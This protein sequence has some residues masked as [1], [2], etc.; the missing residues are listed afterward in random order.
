[1]ASLSTFKLI[2]KCLSAVI[3]TADFTAWQ[4]PHLFY[5]L[6]EAPPSH[7]QKMLPRIARIKRKLLPAI[8]EK[9]VKFVAQKAGG[10]PALLANHKIS[11]SPSFEA[12]SGDPAAPELS[13]SRKEQLAKKPE[14]ERLLHA[15]HREKYYFLS[16][17]SVAV[18]L[19]ER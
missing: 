11:A 18:P 17:K 10:T 7:R 8:P 12:A 3:R 2:W 13:D 6:R 14:T 4:G 19:V 9:F 5:G 1:M 16:G 15:S